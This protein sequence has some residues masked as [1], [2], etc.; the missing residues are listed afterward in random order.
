M[1]T[2]IKFIKYINFFIIY[3]ISV[4]MIY[5][6]NLELLGMGLFI[7]INIVTHIFLLLDIT[8]SPNSFDAVIPI[9]IFPII[10]MFISNIMILITLT[11]LHQLYTK[12]GSSINMNKENKDNFDIY[13]KL[14]I[15]NNILVAV[16]CFIYFNLTEKKNIVSVFSNVQ[17][18]P[19][20]NSNYEKFYDNLTINLFEYPVKVIMTIAMISISV[21]MIVLS[22]RLS[23]LNSQQ[24]YSPPNTN[25][26]KTVPYNRAN[27]F[28]GGLFSN[29]NLN[30][31]MNFY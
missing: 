11:T 18:I 5:T 12:N 2:N 30:Y 27:N 1:N 25:N 20:Y 24:L 16:M 8:S 7:G 14:L 9:L 22:Y 19:F 15:I 21:Y 10:S 6:N 23:K 3:I 29:L 4:F 13:K 28:I 31:M 17:F 26:T